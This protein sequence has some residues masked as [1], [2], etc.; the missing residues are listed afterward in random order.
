M[1]FTTH[2]PRPIQVDLAESMAELAYLGTLLGLPPVLDP[3]YHLAYAAFFDT[4]SSG[5]AEEEEEEVKK[6]ETM[7]LES[8]RT[9]NVSVSS[10]N[11]W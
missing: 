9:Q 7:G 5:G 8:V 2:F 4:L 3:T 10:Q 11:P 1:L 6:E